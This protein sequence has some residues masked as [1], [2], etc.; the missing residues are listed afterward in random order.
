MKKDVVFWIGVKSKNLLTSDKHDNFQYFEY[1]KKT[2]KYWCSKN[3]VIFLE[4]N[5]PS[6]NDHDKHLI[7]W[8]RWFDIQNYLKDIKW[9][10]VA[11][12][13]A[14]YMI[15]WDTPNFFNM[16][17]DA[18]NVFRSLEN[19]R[20]MDQGIKGYQELFPEVNFD[21]KRYID[22][23]FQIFT[24]NHIPFLNKLKKFY[25]NNEDKILK[26]QQT[27]KRGTDQPVYNYLLQQE[28]IDFRFELPNSFNLNHMT[29]FN[30][31]SHNWQLKEDMTPFFIK[32]G[33]LWKYS[34]FDRKQR[35][36]LMKQTWDL[37][38][39]YYE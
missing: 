39:D 5:S 36:P 14:S 12:V 27:I 11:V 7:T 30:W 8:Q 18:L 1:S 20:W 25:V 4:Y 9:N 6:L 17:S 35:Y 22:C 13:D 33:Y 37:V 21:L 24:K 19:V 10:K 32:Y 16:T 28:D 38:K 31:L 2:W 34:G 29:R 26:L 15:K 23:G 3:D